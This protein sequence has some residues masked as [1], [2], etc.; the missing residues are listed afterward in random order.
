MNT[1]F[2]STGGADSDSRIHTMVIQQLKSGQHG[3]EGAQVAVNSLHQPY[4]GN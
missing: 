2:G 1:V 3:N 4:N